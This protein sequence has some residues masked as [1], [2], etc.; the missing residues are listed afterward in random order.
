MPMSA[1]S[2]RSSRDALG[3]LARSGKTQWSLALALF[4]VMLVGPTLGARGAEPSPQPASWVATWGA[5]P[6]SGGPPREPRPGQPNPPGPRSYENRTLRQIVHTS[7]G[8]SAVRIRVSNRD[9]SVPLKIGAAH[10]ALRT[11]GAAIDT[12]TDRALT[13]SGKPSI[14]VPVGAFVLSDATDFEVPPL[15]DLAISLFLPKDTGQPTSHALASQTNFLSQPG[16]FVASE[17]LTGTEPLRSWF[18]LTAVEVLAKEPTG[19]VVTFGDSITDGALSTPDANRRW[20][21]QL[22]R[23]LAERGGGAFA[24]VNAGISGNRVLNDRAGINA[25][26]RFEHDALSQAGVT[27]IVVLL[28]INDIGFGARIPE[29]NVSAEEIIAGHLQMIARAHARGLKIYGATLTPFE[30]AGYYS[31]EGEKKRLAVNEWI[32]TGGAYDAVIDFDAV[33]RDPQH[34][35]RFREGFSRDHLHPNDDGYKAMAEAI[36]LSLFDLN[37]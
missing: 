24:V 25:L 12:H 37:H 19:V 31:P 30:D 10:C 13:F 36:D 5:S 9:G 26:A 23:R 22:A 20:P 3:V 32:R 18:F 8:G 7:V 4:A 14:I 1:I 35:S 34:P 17:Q 15:S 28:G 11:E 16:N 33:V 29:Q 21:D 6:S 27:H 2:V